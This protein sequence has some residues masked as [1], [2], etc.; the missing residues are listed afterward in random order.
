MYAQLYA[1]STRTPMQ[2]TTGQ[3]PQRT[4]NQRHDHNLYH[5]R[6]CSF[7]RLLKTTGKSCF[8]QQLETTKIWKNMMMYN[9]KRCCEYHRSRHCRH[10]YHHH[11]CHRRR[12]CS[13]V[14]MQTTKNAIPKRC[15]R[16]YQRLCQRQHINHNRHQQYFRSRS[17]F[18]SMQITTKNIHNQ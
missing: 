12:A 8:K 18:R 6:S 10:Q 14:C 4:H 2:T 3:Q 5:R 15:Q 1:Q 7:L 11:W 17:R 16:P 13:L 9:L